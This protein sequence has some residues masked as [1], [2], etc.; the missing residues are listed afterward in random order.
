MHYQFRQLALELDKNREALLLEAIND[1][2]GPS[3]VL[4]FTGV[5]CRIDD[6]DPAANA[7]TRS[8]SRRGRRPQM[9]LEAG[10]EQA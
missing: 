9:Y 8:P 6:A 5:L 3:D 7:G 4:I 2:F 10:R 1:L